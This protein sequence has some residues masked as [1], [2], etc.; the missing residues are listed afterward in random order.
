MKTINSLVR[1]QTQRHNYKE[2][3]SFLVSFR[4]TR[5][6]FLKPA[7]ISLRIAEDMIHML[8]VDAHHHRSRQHAAQVE[9]LHVSQGGRLER[10]A[11]LLGAKKTD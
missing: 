8:G 4:G 10:D 1:T 6:F 3:N 7:H 2:Q 5:I 9:G 11:R